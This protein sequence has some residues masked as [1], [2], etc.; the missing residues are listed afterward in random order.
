[1]ELNDSY[2]SERYINRQTGWDLQK[3]SPPITGFI[4]YWPH[5]NSRILIPGCGNAYEAEYLLQKGFTNITLVDIA[6]ALVM[7]LKNHFKDTPVQVIHSD[8]FEHEGEYDLVLEQTFFCALYP[9]LREKY[10]SKMN[11]LLAS[12][13][14]LAGVLFNRQFEGGPPFGGEMDEYRRLFGPLF[15]IKTLE[16]C[17]NSIE[18]R[19]DSE[20]FI[21]LFRL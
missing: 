16:P 2:W 20:V 3:A 8:F 11:S 1:M 15:Q 4:D 5:K 12:G 7:Q 13:G 9:S 6:H 14:S 21:H 18:P 17:L 19:K 10:A